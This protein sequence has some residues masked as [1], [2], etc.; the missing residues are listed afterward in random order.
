MEEDIVK[1]KLVVLGST[2]SIGKQTLQ[3]VDELKDD[4]QVVGLAANNSVESLA[5]QIKKYQ[6]RFASVGTDEARKKLLQILDGYKCEVYVGKEGLVSLARLENIDI[7]LVAVNGINGLIPVLEGMDRGVTIALANKETLVAGG[8]LVME[9]ARKNNVS[10]LPVDSEHSAIYQCIEDNN[11]NAI[12]KLI[13]TASGGPF[14]HYSLE[15]MLNVTPEKALK[16][17][18]WDMGAKITIDSAGLINKGLEVIEARWLFNVPYDKI[19]VVI[20]PQSIFHS[21]VQYVDGSVIAQIGLPDMRVPIQY[22]LT[23]PQ[24]KKNTFPKIDF[25]RL[26]SLTFHKPDLERFSGLGLAFAAGM[27]GGSMPVVYNAV[28]EIAVELFLRGKIKFIEIPIIIE[29]VMSKHVKVDIMDL[30]TIL[31]VDE[32]ARKETLQ[33]FGKS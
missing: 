14:L 17:P 5:Q 24:R 1:K 21:M 7:I 2:G 9:K 32:W 27:E 4:I 15:E 28:N 25:Y 23:Y 16:H 30:D 3:V 26:S 13:L 19:E 6:I 20:H 31:Q 33:Y 18:N 10:I 22:A 29:K 12:E 8:K 11:K